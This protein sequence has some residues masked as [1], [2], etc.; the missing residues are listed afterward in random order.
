[1]ARRL[2]TVQDEL[3]ALHDTDVLVARL[4]EVAE[5]RPALA[6]SAGEA[7][8]IAETRDRGDAHRGERAWQRLD[9]PEVTG[10]L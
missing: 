8:G 10:W 5:R 7:A 3:G 2:R 1:M 9:R 4:R 6:F